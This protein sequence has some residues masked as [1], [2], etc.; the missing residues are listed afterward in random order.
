MATAP[1][2]AKKNP[3][4]IACPKPG[5][6]C[7][8]LRASIAELVRRTPRAALPAFGADTTL[9]VDVPSEV[10][11]LLTGAGSG[12]WF[13]RLTNMMDFENVGFSKRVDGL[14]YLSC[15]DCDLAPIGY[16]DT[17]DEAKEYLIAVDRVK[18]RQ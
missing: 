13:W 5:C 8:I 4:V 6:R 18:Y 7:T 9:S 1:D 15:A 14:Q 11:G 16:H 17:Q 2:S 10:E 3:F 12:G